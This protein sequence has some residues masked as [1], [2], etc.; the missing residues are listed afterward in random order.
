MY[1]TVRQIN[2]SHAKYK[3]AGI[4]PVVEQGGILFFGFGISAWD[5][6][7]SDFGG[8]REKTDADALATALREYAEES[9]SV[10][11][12]LTREMIQDCLVVQ[13]PQT[14]EIIVPVPGPFY[15]YTAR[16]RE[17]L[18]HQPNDE[19]QNIVWL[20]RIQ[21]LQAIHSDQKKKISG[22]K[23]YLMYDKIRAVLLD[24][25]SLI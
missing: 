7:L 5:G 3:R 6:S 12:D 2:W 9:F 15:Q 1:P 23:L 4:I 16:F 25:Q 24:N 22:Q 10:F 20:S 19:I 8:G 17:I 14:I 21:L 13:N 11:G 18:V